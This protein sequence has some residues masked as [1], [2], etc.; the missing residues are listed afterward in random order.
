MPAHTHADHGEFILMHQQMA[1]AWTRWIDEFSL[2]EYGWKV[3]DLHRIEAVLARFV[4]SDCLDEE[5][6]AERDRLLKR[7]K[8]VWRP[9]RLLLDAS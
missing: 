8:E 6:E 2:R 1:S 4:T 5:G 9:R 7:Y 3:S